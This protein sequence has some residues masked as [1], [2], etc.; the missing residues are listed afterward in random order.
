MRICYINDCT[1]FKGVAPCCLDCPEKETC[2]DRCSR[3]ESI[4][5]VGVM[6]EADSGA[7]AEGVNGREHYQ[8]QQC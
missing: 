5:C 8:D 3:K 1:G 2:P 4:H 7:K 6:R